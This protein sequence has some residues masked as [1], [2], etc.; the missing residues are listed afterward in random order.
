LDSE[1][2]LTVT[3]R[4]KLAWLT[5]PSMRLKTAR[6]ARWRDDFNDLYGKT[7]PQ[8]AKA[9]LTR[10]CCGAGRSRLDP[11]KT[12][13]ATVESHWDGI[14]TWQHSPLSNGL[15]EGTNSLV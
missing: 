3:R 8:E 11:I 12:F 4:E 7:D 14:I 10:W 13:V 5:R 1:A 9:Y 6:A 2:N 15:L